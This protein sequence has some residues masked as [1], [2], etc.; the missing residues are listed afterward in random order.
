MGQMSNLEPGGKIKLVSYFTFFN[1]FYFILCVW[2]SCCSSHRSHKR[3]MG[4]P[5]LIVSWELNC[6]PL[7]R[8]ASVLY[9]PA[10]SLWHLVFLSE[11]SSS[12]MTAEAVVLD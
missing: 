2:V 6:S 8:G 3:A 5:E 11:S 9:H 1:Y 4:L 7:V 10:I 12:S